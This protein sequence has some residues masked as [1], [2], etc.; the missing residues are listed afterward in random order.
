MTRSLMSDDSGEYRI[1]D[2]LTPSKLTA[3]VQLSLFLARFAQKVKED[4]CEEA[5]I[6]GIMI[7]LRRLNLI[8][9]RQQAEIGRLT[10]NIETMRAAM[11]TREKEAVQYEG[12]PRRDADE[13]FLDEIFDDEDEFIKWV[14][15]D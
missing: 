7:E 15:E 10:E 11:A 1:V 6:P 3:P 2:D 9:R 14:M 4:V 5:K 12:H 13:C 8:T